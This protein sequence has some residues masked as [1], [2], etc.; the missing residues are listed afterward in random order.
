MPVSGGIYYGKEGDREILKFLKDELENFAS[1]NILEAR[2]E[3][4]FSQEKA[5]VTFI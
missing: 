1:E 3:K 2:L 5:F 4:K